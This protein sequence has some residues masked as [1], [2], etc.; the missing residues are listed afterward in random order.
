MAFVLQNHGPQNRA[1]KELKPVWKLDGLQ[2]VRTVED[3]AD[4]QE[5]NEVA[6][7]EQEPESAA[8]SQSCKAVISADV[9]VGQL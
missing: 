2:V 3:S 4:Q 8:V 7:V 9:S 5:L 1:P 6:Y